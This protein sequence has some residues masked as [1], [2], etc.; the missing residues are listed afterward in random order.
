M[1]VTIARR[2]ILGIG[3]P[4]FAIPEWQALAE[5]YDIHY[6]VPDER[7]QVVSEVKRLCDQEG[8]FDAAYV[9][10]GTA[11][12]SP[13]HPDMLSPLFDKPGHCGLF[14]QG[15]AGKSPIRPPAISTDTAAGYDDVDYPY[16]AANGCYLSNTPHAVTEAT[17]DMAILLMLSAVRGLYESELNA[18]EGRWRKD[19]ALSDDPTEMTIGIIGLGAIGK[20]MARKTKPWDMK[21]LY[22]NRKPLPKEEEEALGA[23]YVSLDTLLAQSD[24]ISTNC[25][26]TPD[27][28][29]I[30]SD[31]EFEK[32]KDGVFIVN[33]AR[34]AVIDEPALIRALESGKVKRAGLDVLTTEPCVSS[35]LYSMKNVTLQ[36]HVGA[37]TKGTI[38]RGERE[39]FANVK[40]YMETG[41]PVNP[42]NKP[43]RVHKSS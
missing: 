4:R 38:L 28:R 19:L 17:A 8:P 10:F 7:E 35:P 9:L 27:T 3:Y 42:V 40:Q 21:I 11:A 31:K 16:L 32:M 6:F 34:G 13:F 39:V 23:T 29:G 43:V 12:Y 37:L 24:I 2:K 22:H 25:P 14:A 41:V 20:S 15:G 1:T 30:L 26:L 36:P 18:R 33:T 5:A